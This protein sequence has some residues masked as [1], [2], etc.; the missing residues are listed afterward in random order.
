[1]LSFSLSLRFWVLYVVNIPR[2]CRISHSMSNLNPL[3]YPTNKYMASMYTSKDIYIYTHIKCICIIIRVDR[4]SPYMAEHGHLK[5]AS[6]FLYHQLIPR[7]NHHGDDT[8]TLRKTG[9]GQW[10]CCRQGGCPGPSAAR[11]MVVGS[12]FG[13]VIAAPFSHA[14]LRA[15]KAAVCPR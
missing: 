11:L 4:Q 12:G 8:R 6:T 3:K 1:M 9:G 13:G 5:L 7:L 15:F 10:I 14:F 2:T